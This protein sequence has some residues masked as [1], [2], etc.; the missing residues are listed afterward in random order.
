MKNYI[1]T[2]TFKSKEAKAKMMEV[3]G[4]ILDLTANSYTKISNS[5]VVNGDR[6]QVLSGWDFNLTSQIPRAPWAR[7]NYNGYKWETEKGS[8]DQKGNIYSLELDVTK[9]VEVVASLDKS[10]LNGVDDETSLSINYIY[11]P[12]EKSMVISDGL[13]NDMF[14]KRNM[15]QKLKE[16]VR[17]RNKLVMEIQGS[18]VVT[19]K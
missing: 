2:H 13:S 1:V 11:P 14:E 16:K 17:R 4:S 5:E 18:V 9:S 12:K 10:S 6:E 19:K 8:V 3:T 7:I 15:E